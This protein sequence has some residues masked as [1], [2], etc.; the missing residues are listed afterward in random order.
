M[1]AVLILDLIMSILNNIMIEERVVAQ[2]VF[3]SVRIVLSLI[4]II[5]VKSFS[6]IVMEL[7]RKGVRLPDN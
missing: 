4:W 7:E 6:S 2:W 3:T 1:I 5:Y